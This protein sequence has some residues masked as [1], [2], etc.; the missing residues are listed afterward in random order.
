MKFAFI[1]C[2]MDNLCPGTEQLG[3]MFANGR[4][5]RATFIPRKPRGDD[6]RN[7]VADA[8]DVPPVFHAQPISPERQRDHA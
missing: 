1:P 8:G 5:N 4:F 7:D 3:V 2:D 6:A